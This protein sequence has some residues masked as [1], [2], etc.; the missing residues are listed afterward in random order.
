MSAALLLLGTVVGLRTEH[1]A[2]G[3]VTV[4]T[5]QVDQTWTGPEADRVEVW[6]R[7]GVTADGRHRAFWDEG[8]PFSV[9]LEGQP[10]VFSLVQRDGHWSPTD[11][12]AIVTPVGGL[13]PSTPCAWTGTRRIEAGGEPGD[14]LVIPLFP[15][16][17][18]YPDG[19]W[20][21]PRIDCAGAPTWEA[22]VR[23][24]RQRA[25]GIE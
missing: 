22:V 13:D 16:M 19:P 20:T 8:P 25:G 11:R 18:G 23:A 15:E 5:V 10:A 6:I 2:D 12:Q 24:L 3:P 4:A 9:V 1:G 14:A 17:P 21:G 7:G